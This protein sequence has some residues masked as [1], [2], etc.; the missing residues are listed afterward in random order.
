MSRPAV[1]Q[2]LR[3]LESANLVYVEPHGNR[4][5]YTIQREGLEE[6]RTYLDA[7]WSDVM[8]AYGDRVQQ[9]TDRE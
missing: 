3:V 2:H 8:T 7:F 5:V 6:L 4:R 9:L 1:S